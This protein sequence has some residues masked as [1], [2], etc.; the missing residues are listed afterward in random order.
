L[1]DVTLHKLFLYGETFPEGLDHVSLAL[2]DSIA[3]R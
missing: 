3:Y 1:L 2:L